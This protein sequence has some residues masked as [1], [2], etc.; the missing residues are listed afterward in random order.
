MPAQAVQWIA[1]FAAMTYGVVAM[2]RG[3]VKH[4]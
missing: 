2:T 3:K 1:A 4:A